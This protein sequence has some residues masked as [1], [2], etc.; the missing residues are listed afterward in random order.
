MISIF[1]WLVLGTPWTENDAH[2]WFESMTN[3]SAMDHLE[4][5]YDT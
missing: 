1:Y 5:M 3:A 2:F 4:P